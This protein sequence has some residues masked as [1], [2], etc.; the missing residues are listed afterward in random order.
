M[1]DVACGFPYHLPATTTYCE[2]LKND[3]GPDGA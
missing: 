1:I 3:K 2:M